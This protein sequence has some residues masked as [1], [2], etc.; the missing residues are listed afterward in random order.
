[1]IICSAEKNK[2]YRD[3]LSFKDLFDDSELDRFVSECPE[4]RKRI[5]TPDAILMSLVGQALNS[6]ESCKNAVENILI[7]RI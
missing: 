1:M 2:P 4:H 3:Y 7:D 6:S 5:Y